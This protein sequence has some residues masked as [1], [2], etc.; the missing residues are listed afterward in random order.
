MLRPQEPRLGCRQVGPDLGLGTQP[1]VGGQMPDNASSDSSRQRV[2]VT[3]GTSGIGRAMVRAFLGAGAMVHVAD[4]V[5]TPPD[6]A[7]MT[8]TDISD[9][10]SVDELFA[11]V[12]EHLGGL[13]VLCNNVGIA[14]PTGPIEDLD[15]GDWDQTMAVNVRSMFL[16]CRR[17][18]PLLRQAG[19]GSI[20][21]TAST[22]GI[23]GYPMRSPY[24]TSKWA[25]V[26]L[27][28]TLAMELGEFGIRVNTICPGSV[29]GDRMDRVIA[30]EA[31]AT[32]TASDEIRAGYENQVS[33]RTFV[34][35]E[36]IASMA[37]F[38][39]SPAARL[40]SG[41]TISVDGGLETLR[42]TW[43]T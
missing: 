25:V 36:D 5:G 11:A 30:A 32:G 37:V 22:A 13:D 39:A 24:A 1:T 41:Q 42:N 6:G 20:L 10:G 8:R 28:A 19:G 9:E 17:A 16:T 4:L 14:G 7:S 38:L 12:E 31:T 43:R 3:G 15:A 2:L 18:V 35:A 29:G 21:N 33:M 26:G 40:V 23:T 34:D 27:G